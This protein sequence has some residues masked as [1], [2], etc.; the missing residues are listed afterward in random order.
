M[1]K[2]YDCPTVVL[3]DVTR[4]KVLLELRENQSLEL[5]QSSMSI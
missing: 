3:I 4:N 2:I 5:S 1:V